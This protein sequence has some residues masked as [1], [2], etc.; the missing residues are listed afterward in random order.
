[1]KN[2]LT[3]IKIYFWLLVI[4]DLMHASF[5]TMPIQAWPIS[6][7]M[8]FGS[9]T[10]CWGCV[11]ILLQIYD[12]REKRFVEVNKDHHVGIVATVLAIGVGGYL[13]DFMG[14][15]FFPISYFFWLVFLYTTVLIGINFS[16]L[17]QK[18]ICNN[19]QTNRPKLFPAAR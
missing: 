17:L 2:S 11:V 7:I 8:F 13:T 1:M 3:T 4:C 12:L 5:F 6:S 10:I 14:Y 9:F 16:I 18:E 19:F 15:L